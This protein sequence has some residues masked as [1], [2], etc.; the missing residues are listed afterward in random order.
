MV[1]VGI[2]RGGTRWP[3]VGGPCGRIR[4]GGM[5]ARRVRMLAGVC[6]VPLVPAHAVSMS[7]AVDGA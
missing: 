5:G 7:C 1:A 2:H 3:G 6:A 4:R